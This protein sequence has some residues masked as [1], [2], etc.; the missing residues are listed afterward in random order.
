MT[1]AQAVPG[2]TATA[3]R[4]AFVASTEP[5]SFV[6]GAGNR[7]VNLIRAVLDPGDALHVVSPFPVLVIV[8]DGVVVD[9]PEGLAIGA[10]TARP[11]N[12]ADLTNRRRGSRSRC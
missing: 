5:F 1:S 8:V 10:G 11:R 4:I 3:H 6:P 2:G 7:D 12:D 9:G